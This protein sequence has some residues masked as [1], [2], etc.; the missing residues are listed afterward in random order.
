MTELAN[1]AM[2]IS[3]LAT[4]VLFCSALTYGQRS[5]GPKQQGVYLSPSAFRE[6]PAG[7][8]ADLKQR[9]C[10]IPQSGDNGK[11]NNVIR[12]EFARPGQMDLAVL[13]SV[14]GVSSILVYRKGE[15]RAPASL[16][17]RADRNYLETDFQ[18]R[19]IFVRAIQPV[20]QDFILEHY[21][22]YGGPKPP[23]IDHQGIEDEFLEKA[24]I[25]WYF[26]RG[27]WLK[28]TGAD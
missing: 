5:G 23:A 3:L 21:R 25:V 7:V 26:E 19:Q 1:K 10:L 16:A 4:V 12:G 15:N 22:A 14:R 13:C 11:P 8:S 28:L 17:T 18:G 9:G 6:L 20:G 24:S 2:H 27:R